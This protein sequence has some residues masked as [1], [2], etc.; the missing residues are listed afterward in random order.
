MKGSPHSI[1]KLHLWHK[2]TAIFVSI[3]FSLLNCFEFTPSVIASEAKQ[4]LSSEI[5]SVAT[6]PRNDELTIPP[7]FGSI[8]EFHQ[9]ISGKTIVY[10][11]DAHDS[12]EA[13]EHIA[14][15]ISQL[16]KDNG[17]KTVFEEGY[18]G[19]VPTDQYFGFIKDP[20][21]KEKVHD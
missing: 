13:Q 21:V 11:Q 14:G 20:K 12:L 18:E 8:E 17:I 7:E 6:L 5:A 10:I 19:E 4:S 9:G 2:T 1:G 3:C 16:V 15:M